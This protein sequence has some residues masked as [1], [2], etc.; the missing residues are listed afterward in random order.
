M[1]KPEPEREVNT[2]EVKKDDIITAEETKEVID[3]PVEE[4]KKEVAPEVVVKEEVPEKNNTT[5][6][7]S[8]ITVT[9]SGDSRK[10]SPEEI[11]RNSMYEAAK[12]ISD[13]SLSN[14]VDEAYIDKAVNHVAY[15]IDTLRSLK[16]WNN[17]FEKKLLNTVVD[18]KHQQFDLKAEQE[19][20]KL[21]ATAD[22]YAIKGEEREVI[23]EVVALRDID[24]GNYD[25]PDTSDESVPE[26]KEIDSLDSN[27]EDEYLAYEEAEYDSNDNSEEFE[28]YEEYENNES[29]DD[30][31]EALTGIATFKGKFIDISTKFPSSSSKNVLVIEDGNG[32]LLTVG[33]NHLLVVDRIDGMDTSETVIVSKQYIETL[34]NAINNKVEEES[35]NKKVKVEFEPDPNKAEE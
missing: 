24:T 1:K 14:K 12:N 35:E 31:E 21:V 3:T 5:N 30:G 27:D 25:E 6:L 8:P 20:D 16:D 33:D 26:A 28:C 29:E 2:I 15:I 34:D 23:F 19:D 11:L 13:A 22:V 7:R 17:D 4:V 10:K 32:S 9:G 18:D